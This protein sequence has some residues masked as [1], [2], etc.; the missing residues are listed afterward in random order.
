M[1]GDGGVLRMMRFGDG[2]RKEEA[3]DEFGDEMRNEV[4]FGLSDREVGGVNRL[5]RWL[6]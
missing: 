1:V 5:R 4:E 3:E 6:A 2:R